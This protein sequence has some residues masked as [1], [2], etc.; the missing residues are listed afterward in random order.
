MQGDRVCVELDQRLPRRHPLPRFD[1]GREALASQVHRIQP[2]MQQHLHPVVPGDADGVPGVLQVAD[3]PG[4]RCTQHLRSGINAQ[5]VAN[6]AAGK[7]RVRDLI[8]RQQ[9][10][11]QRRQQFQ[12]LG[13]DHDFTCN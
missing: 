4:Q 12:L 11:G 8:E 1:Q 10:T 2:D 13:C 6:Q 3:H 7:H 9:H 5:T